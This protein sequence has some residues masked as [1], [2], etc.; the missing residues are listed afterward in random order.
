M[1]ELPFLLAKA[2]ELERLKAAISDLS[3]FQR[4]SQEED[5]KFELIKSWQIV[6]LVVVMTT[7]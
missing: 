4:M 7:Y 3:V 1:D 6:S 5:R 2:G